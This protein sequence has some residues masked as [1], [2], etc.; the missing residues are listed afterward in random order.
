MTR[1]NVLFAIVGL[2]AG[3]VCAFHLVV[4]FNQHQPAA[5]QARVAAG[6]A[7]AGGAAEGALPSNEVKERQR[8]QTAAETAAQAA[9]Q[10]AQNFDAQAKA[11]QAFM[12]AR[13]YE[14]AIDFLTRANQLRPD[15]YDTLVKL[16]HA[17]NGARR[18]DTAEKW[19]LAALAKRPDDGNVR[20]ELAATYF[21]REPSQPEKA[22][23]V[24]REALERDPGHVASLHNLAYLLI[25]SEKFD[26]AAE[27]LDR[28]ERVD[29]SYP[30][31]P[32]L[33]EELR[34]AR[35]DGPDDAKKSPA[36]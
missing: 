28:L 1:E 33:R 7:G 34:K 30:Q 9:R 27:S 19:Y 6:A 15:D 21:F 4:Y 20:S 17:N 32:G 3:Y 13:D 8:L 25:M 22:M 14:G 31:L 2:L 26:E 18:F 10:D 16:G 5:A 11:A 24:L 23:A 36:D 35:E 12:D 29:P